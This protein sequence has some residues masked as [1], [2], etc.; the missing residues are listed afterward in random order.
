MP[1]D[2]YPTEDELETIKNWEITSSLGDA[3]YHNFMS[4]IKHCW[5]WHNY[6]EKNGDKYTL[7]TGGWSGNEEIIAAMKSNQIF[8]LFYWESS[9]RG[10]LH[11]FSP[12]CKMRNEKENEK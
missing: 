3:S 10:G 7:I 8:W 11:I 9:D 2:G 5:H 4:F 12:I 6:I 1:C